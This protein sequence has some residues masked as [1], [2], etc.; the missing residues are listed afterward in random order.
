MKRRFNTHLVAVLVAFCA[1]FIGSCSKSDDD[2][3]SG[4]DYYFRFKANGTTVDYSNTVKQAYYP[5]IT[6]VNTTTTGVTGFSAIISASA[7]VNQ[8]LRNAV[9]VIMNGDAAFTT[10]IDYTTASNS[11]LTLMN[12]GYYDNSGKLFVMSKSLNIVNN[13]GSATVRYSVINDDIIQGVFSAH[14]YD[15]TQNAHVEITEGAFRVKRKP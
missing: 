13:P 4:G 7:D 3:G 12:F 14:L 2:G 15:N 1:I 6:S 10:G 5:G 11:P 9:S 8:V